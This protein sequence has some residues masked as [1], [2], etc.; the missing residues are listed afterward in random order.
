MKRCG[1]I[2]FFATPRFSTLLSMNALTPVGD[3]R[4]ETRRAWA[5]I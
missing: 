4:G 5:P 1:N 2:D 3:N